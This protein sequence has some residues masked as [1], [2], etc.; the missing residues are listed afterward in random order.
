M[1]QTQPVEPPRR[2][3]DALRYV[4]PGLILT[5]GIVGTGELVLAPRVA[6]EH[7]FALLWLIVLGCM[8]K[9]FTQIELGRYAVATDTTTLQVLDALPGPRWRAG[10][11]LW[12]WLPVFAAMI[13][14]SS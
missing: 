1:P 11:M 10:W 7:G 12:I 3:V 4:G 5:A 6:S 13:R 14:P 9:V 8:V 2:L